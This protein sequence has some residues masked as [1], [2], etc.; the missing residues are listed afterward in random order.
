MKQ[1][2]WISVTLFFLPLGMF[3][4]SHPETTP[5]DESIELLARLHEAVNQVILYHV[6]GLLA[7]GLWL[8]LIPFT[9]V[10]MYFLATGALIFAGGA[11]LVGLIRLF[12]GMAVVREL[13]DFAPVFANEVEE[14]HVKKQQRVIHILTWFWI[15]LGILALLWIAFLQIMGSW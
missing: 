3:A 8:M 11:F 4:A 13:K 2:A 9:G 14:K 6:A 12:G 5:A 7:L 10:V 1:I 15:T